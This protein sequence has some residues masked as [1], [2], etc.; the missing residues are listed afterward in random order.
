MHDF[1][2]SSLLPPCLAEVSTIALCAKIAASKALPHLTGLQWRLPD[3]R[4]LYLGK[5][6]GLRDN[7]K[8]IFITE[9]ENV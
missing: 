9:E 5:W 8:H 2:W 1:N 6:R 7:W 3:Y 4:Q